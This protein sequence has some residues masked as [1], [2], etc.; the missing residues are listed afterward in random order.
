MPPDEPSWWYADDGSGAWAQRLLAPLSWLYAREAQRRFVRTEPYQSRLP[1]ICVGNFV[2]GG[3]GKTPLAVAIA[4][5]VQTM[6]GV[7]VFLSRGYGGA[8]RGPQLVDQRQHRSA[9]V[10]DEPLLLART[11]TVMIA[12]DRRAGAQAIEQ[13][14]DAA[15][16]IVMDDGLQNPALKK[17]LVIA[18]VDG[19]RGIGNGAVIPAGP[20]R[21]PIDFQLGMADA[22]V[23]NGKG[24]AARPDHVLE[25]LRQQFP[26]PVL[27]ADVAAAGETDWLYD[28]PV[29]AFS[30]IG[31]PQRFFNLLESLGARVVDRRTF[32]DHHQFKEREA[33]ELMR[34]ATAQGARLV[35]TEKDWVR[36][37]HEGGALEALQTVTA[38]VPIELRFA[39]QEQGRLAALIDG[40]LAGRAYPRGVPQS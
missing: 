20:L 29:L 38:P 15:S 8:M 22:V 40:V 19:G 25:R 3:T 10:G 11:A 37:S 35:T 21:A 4:K 9:D 17:D 16:V 32:G 36:L 13:E 1:V 23:V 31:N 2:A 30:G 28:L 12:R 6:G 34:A 5:H 26:G 7:P 14:A 39:E 18:V 33:H 24:S 27:H